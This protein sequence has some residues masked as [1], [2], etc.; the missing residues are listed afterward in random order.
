MAGA[1]QIWKLLRDIDPEKLGPVLKAEKPYEPPG[2]HSAKDTKDGLRII[3]VELTFWTEELSQYSDKTQLRAVEPYI[4]LHP[5]DAARLGLS[6]GDIMFECK[7]QVN[8]GIAKGVAVQ[9]RLSHQPGGGD[10]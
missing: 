1:G 2:E 8:G 5:E 3:E 7:L 9:P 4:M 6:P 10:A